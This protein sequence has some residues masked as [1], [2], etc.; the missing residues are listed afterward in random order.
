MSY[1]LLS[2]EQDTM[3]KCIILAEWAKE[4]EI[5]CRMFTKFILSN[6]TTASGIEF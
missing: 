2:H 4:K 5:K 6:F 3:T 1:E